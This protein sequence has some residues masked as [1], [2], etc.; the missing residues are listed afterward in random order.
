MAI[1]SCSTNISTNYC[2]S[3]HTIHHLKGKPVIKTE[4]IYTWETTLW[5]P[6]EA[7]WTQEV[8]HLMTS[9]LVISSPPI[10]CA[11]A[12]KNLSVNLGDSIVCVHVIFSEFNCLLQQGSFVR[13]ITIRLIWFS[14]SFILSRNN[15]DLHL[16]IRI[17]GMVELYLIV[18]PF[19]RIV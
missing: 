10:R 4:Y 12:W 19:W 1:A 6:S 8:M 9:S 14:N 3:N 11:P 2:T 15:N 17:D 16:E 18:S 13:Q 5:S 7:F